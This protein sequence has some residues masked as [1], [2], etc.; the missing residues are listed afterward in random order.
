MCWFQDKFFGSL[1]RQEI[2]D[3]AKADFSLAV[4]ANEPLDNAPIPRLVFRLA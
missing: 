2:V 4:L 1:L 3:A